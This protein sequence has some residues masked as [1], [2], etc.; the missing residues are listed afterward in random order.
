MSSSLWVSMT[1]LEA[2]EK[3]MSVISNNLANVNTT[4]FKR[5][6]ASFEDLFYQT[7]QEAG[8][9]ANQQ[10]ELPVGLQ[11]GTG[12]KVT[13]TEKVFTPGDIKTTGQPLDLAIAGQGFFQ[14]QK[15]D[16]SIAYTRDGQFQK[17]ADGT[18]VTMEGLPVQ[19]SITIPD[20][21]TSVSI[22]TDGTVSVTQA[23]STDSQSLGQLTLVSFVN[24]CGLKALGGNL[25][26]QTTASGAPNESI[27][28]QDGLG[29]IKQHSLEGSNVSVVQE[30][31][32][33]ISTQRAYDMNSKVVSAA[34][35]M[36]KEVSQVG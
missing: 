11:L 15:P 4:A 22:G 7:E 35:Q 26:Q 19:P 13:G 9:M 28:G 25:Y 27:A 8:A 6:R 24:P 14:V 5:D 3:Q 33:M 20:D 18:L 1:G 17:N 12:V 29:E 16:G 31:V 34:D 30:M 32:D 21:A 23:G 2:Q 10:N 36:L